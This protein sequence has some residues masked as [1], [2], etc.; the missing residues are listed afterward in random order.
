MASTIVLLA[1]LFLAGLGIGFL[2]G[3]LGIGG[4]VLLA[5]ILIFVPPWLG[6]TPIAPHQV[7]AIAII[8]ALAAA[9]AGLPA[10]WQRGVVQPTLALTMGITATIAA[11]LG[12]ILSLFLD[13][14]A[15][16]VLFASMSTLAVALMLLPRR[17]DHVTVD[18][19][20]IRF[21]IPLAIAV[22]AVI[23]FLGS[24]VGSSGSFLLTPAMLYVLKIPMRVAVGTM[25]AVVVMAAA[26]GSVGKVVT[27]QV[28]WTLAAVVVVGALQGARWGSKRSA[29]VPADTLRWLFAAAVMVASVGLWQKVLVG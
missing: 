18:S 27:G 5:P 20:Q 3:L 21:S 25:L 15:F 12:A 7:A 1:V 16:L 29:H 22:S 26:A 11:T 9:L 17:D 4:A 23:S 14:Q 2:S 28:P 10:H 13:N 19:S 24:L 6:L 8:Q